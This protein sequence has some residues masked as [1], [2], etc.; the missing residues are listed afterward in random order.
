MPT[1]DELILRIEA[2]AYQLKSELKSAES[3]TKASASRMSSAFGG[4]KSSIAN[5]GK[6]IANFRVGLG[7]LLGAGGLTALLKSAIDTGDEL[8]KL[9]QK[10]GV[11]VESL[12]AL[13]YAAELSDV[14]T[15]QLQA[16]LR[17]LANNMQQ[18]AQGS[19][20]AK[21]VFRALG[22]AVTD[23]AGN[24]RQ[25]ETVLMELM[26]AF[27]GMEDGMG[28]AALAS[29]VFGRA[30][31]ELLPFLN[32]GRSGFEALR[33]EAERLGIVISGEAAQAAENFNDDLSR[34]KFAVEG[35]A[36]AI[37]KDA[38]PMLNNITKAM[39]L[40]AE[41][42]GI[43]RSIWVGLGGL[44]QALFVGADTPIANINRDI[45]KAK[46][47]LADLQQMSQAPRALAHKAL[48]VDTFSKDI[49][50]AQA[51]IADLEKRRN[52]ILNPVVKKKDA[53]Q[54]AKKAAPKLRTADE[55]SAAKDKAKNQQDAVLGL[56]R[57]IATTKE[58]TEV[59]RVRFEIEKGA[60][61]DFD[62]ATKQR[63]LGLAQQAD[64]E[65]KSIENTKEGK[66]KA[67]E[68]RKEQERLNEELKR[69]AQAYTDQFDP[70]RKLQ[71]EIM[72]LNELK[73][74]GLLSDDIVIKGTLALNKEIDETKKKLNE[75][76]DEVTQ[77]AIQAARNIESNLGDQLFNFMQ[78]KFDSIGDGFKAMI[79]RMVADLL[80]SQLSKMLF[81][82][83]GNTNQIGGF[84]GNLFGFGGSSAPSPGG[85]QLPV[86]FGG[87][88]DT[89]SS[90]GFMSGI[91]S[92]FGG[93]RANG[94]PVAANMPFIV[95]EKGAELFVP[96]VPG[97]VFSNKEL[98]GL[99]GG[100]V[101]VSMN[102]STPDANSF[103]KSSGQIASQLGLAINR[104]VRRNT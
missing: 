37:A 35:F 65:R 99:T 4:L 100:N 49:E 54:S 12:S 64:A 61:K 72:R 52:D 44:G 40:A 53:E 16:G 58:A 74:K 21:E 60:Y 38:L 46:E 51:K 94:G 28:K 24:L 36:Q 20:Q 71:N 84:V 67:E 9:S 70:V 27:A 48:G 76:S 83:F 55:I 6:S 80:A 39:T 25:T 104:A 34:L 85:A 10:V 82:D 15:Q 78:G 63:I 2:D 81:G 5:V 26:D 18:A 87:T 47:Q 86:P 102:I 31:L 59:A 8:N 62:A 96:K 73:E 33:K 57:E 14:S 91:S 101:T 50:K 13:R 43:L 66:R 17:G 79:D 11:S 103:S 77:F 68:K 22:I 92:F 1:I 30:G 32:Q 29:E 98:G 56:E 93:F 41:E 19:D 95:G 69:E 89:A 75:A 45:S 42:G 23:S 7:T 88:A 90:G 97:K 3:A